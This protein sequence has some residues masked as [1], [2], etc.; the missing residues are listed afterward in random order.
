MLHP[1]LLPVQCSS[2]GVWWLVPRFLLVDTLLAAL[3]RSCLEVSVD[4]FQGLISEEKECCHRSTPRAKQDRSS[5]AHTSIQ[6][7]SWWSSSFFFSTSMNAQVAN[8][9][10]A[11]KSC[12]EVFLETPACPRDLWR[13]GLKKQCEKLDVYALCL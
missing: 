4:R 1:C 3:S 8:V 2:V 11:S 10:R 7:R 6:P 12:R 13:S 5:R 9:A